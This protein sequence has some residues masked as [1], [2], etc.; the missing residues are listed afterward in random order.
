MGSVVFGG[1][2]LAWPQSSAVPRVGI[3]G[4][5]SGASVLPDAFIEGLK[6]SRNILIEE[7]SAEGRLERIPDLVDELVRLPVDVIFAGGGPEVIDA[8]RR[9][10]RIIPIIAIDLERDPVTAGLVQSLARPG[11]NLTGVFLDLPELAGKLLQLLLEAVPGS[12]QVAVL[13]STPLAEDL[14]HGTEAAARTAR[15][16]LQSL[17]IA[18]Q[19]E[20]DGALAAARRERAQGLVVLSSPLIFLLRQRIVELTVKYRIPAIS[21]F[22]IFARIGLLMAVWPEL[23]RHVPALRALRGACPPGH[24]ARQPPHRTLEPIRDDPEREDRQGARTHAS[25]VA[26]SARGRSDRVKSESSEAREWH[27]IIRASVRECCGM[28]CSASGDSVPGVRAR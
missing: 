14:F 2:R 24:Q 11:G 4:T 25:P 18:A 3:V 1:P 7:R 9:A 12:R 21:L 26:A 13:W 8:A 20:L 16:S 17:P 15:I 6:D 23:R 27:R 19:D 22:T 5:G 10:M 28:G